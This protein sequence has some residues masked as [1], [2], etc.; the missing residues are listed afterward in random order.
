MV[1]LIGG[2]STDKYQYTVVFTSA[3]DEAKKDAVIKKIQDT[4]D[5]YIIDGTIQAAADAIHVDSF[6][7]SETYP[8]HKG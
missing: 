1:S 8:I 5:P 2:E 4:L 7:V 6:T 3:K